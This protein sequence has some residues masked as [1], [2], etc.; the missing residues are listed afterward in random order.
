MCGSC[1]QSDGGAVVSLGTKA[2]FK[3][4]SH[5]PNIIPRQ[6]CYSLRASQLKQINAIGF[7]KPNREV[8]VPRREGIVFAAGDKLLQGIGT[9][10]IEQSVRY[11]L[12]V[13]PVP[14]QRFFNETSDGVS[15]L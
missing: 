9:R 10:G 12:I 5:I 4:G 1:G 3:G 13:E 7:Q 14:N 15:D 2:P 8:R 11:F 6:V